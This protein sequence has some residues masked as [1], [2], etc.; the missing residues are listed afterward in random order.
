VEKEVCAC[1]LFVSLTRH[2]LIDP[3]EVSWEENAA[4]PPS[5]GS[6]DLLMRAS[7]QASILD[8][9]AAW[10]GVD[11]LLWK[12]EVVALCAAGKDLP[13]CVPVR[14]FYIFLS[15]QTAPPQRS[16]EKSP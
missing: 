10:D 6:F 5:D 15:L 4:A 16:A 14:L 7:R 8:R 3:S 11:R 2:D 12:Y 13:L 1:L 9:F